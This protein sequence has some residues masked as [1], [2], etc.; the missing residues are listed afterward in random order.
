MNIKVLSN[1]K[2]ICT[3]VLKDATPALA[4][5]L[6]RI[7]ISEVPTMA[8]ER[9]DYHENTSALFDE[10]IAHRLGCIPIVFDPNKFSKR[11]ECKCGGK[12]CSL[13]QVV[14][15]LEK[16]G[17]GIAYSKDLKSSSRSVRPT[18]PKFPIV[19]L[20]KGHEINLD[21]IARLGTGREHAKWQAAN[22]A[23]L[24]YPKIEMEK[25]FRDLKKV[26]DSCPK[27]ALEIKNR[28]LSIPD[29]FRADECRMAEEVS[30]GKVRIV[31][32]DT[33]FVFRVESVSGLKPKYIIEEAARILSG[34]ANEFKT[35]LKKV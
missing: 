35:H 23:Y 4:N 17:P 27:G 28:K 11:E 19:Q 25:G 2:D 8:V 34:K 21:A 26:V 6:R 3:F 20:L 31:N 24:Y 10:I 32:D 9:V 12:G 1:K 16:K 13:C 7:M 5:S 18:S 14:F 29:P 15:H 22:V 33:T 30:G